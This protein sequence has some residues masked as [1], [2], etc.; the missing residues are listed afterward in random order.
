MTKII[1]AGYYGFDNI[2]DE[3]ILMSMVKAFKSINKE[4]EI[5]VLSNN[6]EKTSKEY[7]VKSINR[8]NLVAFIKELKNCNLFIS[9]GGSLLQ[10][11]TGWKSIPF[12]IG[13]LV[14]AKIMRK[15]TVVFA[16]G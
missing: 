15:K 13:Q 3:A 14:L 6:P 9:G 4:I 5:L 1:I 2:G 7:K 16:Q 10:D 12:Y 8:N 11:I